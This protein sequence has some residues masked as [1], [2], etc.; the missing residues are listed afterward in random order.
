M[1]PAI[2]STSKQTVSRP[3]IVGILILIAILIF[4]GSTLFTYTPPLPTIPVDTA[5]ANALIPYTSDSSGA[6]IYYP[7]GWEIREIPS[8]LGFRIFQIAPDTATLETLDI[9]QQGGVL[10]LSVLS[11]ELVGAT[12]SPTTTV[13]SLLELQSQGMAEIPGATLTEPTQTY[14]L[15]EWEIARQVYRIVSTEAPYVSIQTLQKRG[16]VYIG[17][18]GFALE[19]HVATARPLFDAIL[20]KV[21]V[22]DS[23]ASQ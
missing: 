19:T 9:P 1:K 14:R 10:S 22:P 3:V 5:V 11:A 4:G 7:D 2:S 18:S 15:G 12:N 20:S 17:A 8:E 21:T 6:T 16:D 23:G 13:A